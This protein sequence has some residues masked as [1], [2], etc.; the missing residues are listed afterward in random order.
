MNPYIGHEFQLYGVEEYT[1][2]GGRK[3]GM[4]ILHVKNGLG[5]DMT[6][7]L[8]RGGDISSLSLHGKN[9]SYLT[10]NGYVSSRYYDDKGSGWIKT[11]TAGFLTTCGFNNAGSPCSDEDGEYP[12]HGSV[13]QIPVDSYS[14]EV[15]EDRIVI[16]TVLLDEY[17]FNRKL[18]RVRLITVYLNKNE[19]EI[20]DEIENRGDKK[21][22]VLCLYHMNIGYPLLKEDSIVVIDSKKVIAR[23]K[24]AQE[25]IKEW[26]K[27]EKPTP[28]YQEMCYYHKMKSNIGRAGIYSPSEDIGVMITYDS[29]KLK[30]FTQWKMMGVRDYVLGL[31]PGNV[32]ADGYVVNKAKN[33]LTYLS[34]NEK[35]NYKLRIQLFDNIDEFKG[36]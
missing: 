30:E 11:F 27:M 16:R 4:K 5:L 7:S 19:F 12:L 10:P 13:N 35:L 6:I 9:M 34:P 18:K 14:Y 29:T 28:N 36:R 2:N 32:N 8:D 3:E 20:E 25:G 23:D 33:L 15:L 22:P 26:N 21:T 31:E 1:L 24:H 17:I